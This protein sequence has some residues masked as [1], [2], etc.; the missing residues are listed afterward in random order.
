M[1]KINFKNVYILTGKDKKYILIVY[2]ISSNHYVGIPLVNE[3]SEHTIYCSSIKMYA[4]VSKI[5]D[6]NKNTISNCLYIQGKPVK[7]SEDDFINILKASK[8]VLINFLRY[9]V[10]IG[11]DDINYLKWCKDKYIL[12]QLDD[13]KQKY[14][15][16]GIYWVNFGFGVGSE[17]RKMRPAILWKNTADH[18]NWTVIPLTTKRRNDKYY[19]HCD[20]ECLSEGTAKI[21]NLMNMSSKRIVAPYFSN[22]KIAILT[23]N[24]YNNVKKAISKYYLY[25]DFFEKC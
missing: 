7:V 19:F 22:H 17:L 21:E 23:N 1:L 6:Y 18:K 12:N 2:N 13:I 4:D 10:G 14:I 24:D 8:K 20:L 9:K 3:K 16:N 25:E 5:R 15:Q 11:V